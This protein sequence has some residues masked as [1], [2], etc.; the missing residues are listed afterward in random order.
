[1]IESDRTKTFKDLELGDLPPVPPIQDGCFSFP[2][3]S[4]FFS[5]EMWFKCIALDPYWIKKKAND[6]QLSPFEQ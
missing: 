3:L 1:M 4:L 2:K 5:L 6:S